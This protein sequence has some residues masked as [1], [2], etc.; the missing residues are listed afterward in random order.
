MRGDPKRADP[1]TRITDEPEASGEPSEAESWALLLSIDGLGPAGFGALL[2][3]YGSGRG[4]L[5]AAGRPRAATTLAGIASA[6]EGRTAFGARVG[7]GIVA[8]AA[9]AGP[10]LGV[11]RGS[12]LRIVTLDDPGYPARLRAISLPPPALLVQ[13]D[14]ALL[15]GRRMIAVVG[16]RRPTERGR[17][18]AAR[19]AAAISRCGAVVVSGLAVGIDGAAHAAVVAEGGQTIAVLGSGHG[20]LYPRAHARLA[21]ELIA[22]GGAI[23]AERFPDRGPTAGTFP[24]RNRVI[25]GLAEATIVV[26]AGSRSGALITAEWALEQGRECFLVPG[27]IDEPR[28]AG[29]LAWLREYPAA[30]RIVAGIPELIEDLGLIDLPAAEMPDRP[31][32]E[33][34]QESR[35][36]H[37]SVPVSRPSVGAELVELG[38]TARQ[39]A[40]ALCSGHGSID[41]LAAA[42]GHPVATILGAITILELRGLATSTYGRYRAAGRLAAAVPENHDAAQA[43]ARSK[44]RRLP[45]RPGPC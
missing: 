39:V 20:R 45:V 32:E 22:A 43:R 26:E 27:P 3:A 36:P 7:E 37:G 5:R 2:A 9:D 1:V 19:I 4:I 25:S 12:G 8:L 18:T 38:T 16:T 11:L 29:C 28:S 13:G 10:R 24:Q 30:T 21:A 14:A 34:R 40:E 15:D 6:A 31:G 23:V 17:L 35:P 42:T 41:E 44:I 33:R